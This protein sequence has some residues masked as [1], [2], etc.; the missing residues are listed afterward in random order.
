MAEAIFREMV[1]TDA[2]EVASAGI[3]AISGDSASPYAQQVLLDKNISHQHSSQI[4][5]SD[6]IEWADLILTMTYSHK[7]V[8]LSHYAQS[9]GKVYTLKEYVTEE[10][11]L[12]TD[13]LLNWDIADPFGGSYEQYRIAA[14]EI[15]ESLQKL[16]KKLKI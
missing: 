8:L 1:G 12:D 2:I 3:A 4:I 6:L 13:K 9:Q 15:E 5:T 11:E 16:Y 7:I 14:I 10:N